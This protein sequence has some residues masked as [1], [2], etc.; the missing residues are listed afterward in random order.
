MPTYTITTKA[1][2]TTVRAGSPERAAEIFVRRSNRRRVA[3]RT[4]GTRGMSGQ[5]QGYE[6]ARGGGQTSAGPAFVVKG[7]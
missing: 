1:A 2:T 6:S 3:Q 5:F 4:T 7:G